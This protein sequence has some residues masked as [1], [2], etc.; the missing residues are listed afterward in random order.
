MFL[1]NAR[2][3]HF[4]MCS[5]DPEALARFYGRALDMVV[6]RRTNGYVA[7]G[8]QRKIEFVS[9]AKK[10]AAYSAYSFP[11][12]SSLEALRAHLLAQGVILSASPSP[13]FGDESFA[14]T[15]PDGHVVVFGVATEIFTFVGQS[16]RKIAR[17]QHFVTASPHIE[18]LL[19]FYSKVFDFRVSDEVKDDAGKLRAVFLR[20]DSEHHSRAIFY[21]HEIR[22]DHHCYEVEDWSSI[23]DWGDSMGEQRIDLK[24]GPGRH[25]PGHNLFFMI[26]DPDGNWIEISTELDIVPDGAPIGL[27][28]HE[29][30]TL[31]TWGQAFLRS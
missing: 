3:D 7:F 31:N 16:K 15:D 24:W 17:L 19:D 28:P 27:W 2:L 29:E 6:E 30:R 8:P 13:F 20:T 10:N 25:G 11:D 5:P 4:C 23:R 22:L 1:Q 12:V 9:G 18:R 14:V 26:H 21:A